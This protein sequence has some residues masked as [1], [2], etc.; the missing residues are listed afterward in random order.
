MAKALGSSAEDEPLPNLSSLHSLMHGHVGLLFTSRPPAAIC[1]FFESYSRT[2]FAR[3]GVVASQDIAI[4]AG[5]VYSRAGQIPVE[6]D[7]PLPAAMEPTVRKWALPTR[8]DKGK[9]ML[10]SGYTICKEG[11]LLNS[12]QTA[13]LKIFGIE[14][15]EFAIRLKGYLL[16]LLLRKNSTCGLST[17]SSLMS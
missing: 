6:D 9:V 8:L 17:Y 2:S 12:H 13:L 14:L 3:A 10:D 16:F 1:D 4:P 15:A 11:D 5:Q 7:V